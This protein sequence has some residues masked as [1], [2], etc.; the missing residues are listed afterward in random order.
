MYIEVFIK[1]NLEG[2]TTIFNTKFFHST[3]RWRRLKNEIKGVEVGGQWCEEPLKVRFE[4]KKMFENRFKAFEVVLE[5][6]E[7]KALTQDDNDSLVA[8]F[9][10][11]EVREAVWQCN[12]SKSPRPDGFNFNFIKNSWEVIKKEV[13]RAM[14]SFYAS[15]HIPKGCNASFIALVPKVRDPILL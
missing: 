10:G 4:A 7:F 15:G 3:L 12:G 11:K 13:M 14:D 6:V 9:S 2:A 8:E 1:H 5:G